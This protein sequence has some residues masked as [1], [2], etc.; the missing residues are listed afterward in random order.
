MPADTVDLSD[1]PVIIEL[2]VLWGDMDAFQHVNNVVYFRYFESARVAYAD[3][4]A[5]YQMQQATG[6]GPI[7]AAT[8]CDFL[9]PLRYPDSIRVGCR[10]V[11]LTE[12]EIRQE[13]AIC[14]ERQD[15][16]VAIGTATVMAY[17]YRS[18]RRSTFPQAL[19][20]RVLAMEDGLLLSP[21]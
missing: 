10:T 21:A 12:M 2:P 15:R 1:F 6:I 7:L 14:S 5:L 20:E 17:D 16:L 4:I 8:S 18:L 19:L 9:R 11:H 13:H 3:R